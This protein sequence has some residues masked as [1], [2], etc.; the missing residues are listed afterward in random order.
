MKCLDFRKGLVL[1]GGAARGLLHLGIIKALEME[2]FSVDLIVGTSMG[3]LIGA[4][5][6][7]QGSMDKV[8]GKLETHLNSDVFKE[9]QFEFMSRWSKEQE[10]DSFLSRITTTFSKGFFYSNLLSKRSFIS[11][12]TFAGNIN[13]LIDDIDIRDTKI[14][15][16]CV[17]LD[18][19]SGDEILMEKGS[20]RR[21]V[22]A[23]CALPVVLPPVEIGPHTLV[24]GSWVNN[25]PV[26]WAYELGAHMVIAVYT[27]ENPSCGV[28]PFE[29]FLEIVT[30]ADEAARLALSNLEVK[31]ADVIITPDVYD[32]P[33]Y[34]F[35]IWEEM[36]RRGLRFIRYSID[37]IR[38]TERRL[39][40]KRLLFS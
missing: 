22:Q 10:P 25:V 26:G 30:R 18:L 32:V 8:I 29:T 11:E 7:S 12:E 28:Q 38:S 31:K 17:A 23:S 5:Y 21:A 19:C 16:G 1:S 20:L 27:R 36:Y 6:A 33:W 34:D 37:E 15:F 3:A 2:R 24:D 39:R 4:M 13:A 9:T 40:L 14:K 35:V